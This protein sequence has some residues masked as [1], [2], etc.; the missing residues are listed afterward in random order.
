V[1]TILLIVLVA[2]PVNLSHGRTSGTGVLTQSTYTVTFSASGLPAGSTW[3]VDF[4]G[5]AVSPVPYNDKVT[6]SGIVSGTWNFNVGSVPGYNADPSAGR[7]E[8]DGA[9]V[10]KTILFTP[11]A[12]PPGNGPVAQGSIPPASY[13]LI[14][15]IVVAAV[16]V[17]TVGVFILSKRRRE[18]VSTTRKS[19][20]Y[21]KSRNGT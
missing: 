18:R 1:S 16:M 3:S 11:S 13:P 4:Q 15:G 2:P 14:V 20:N 9:N 19:S 7:I 5:A 6:L 8:V 10:S 21:Q 17:T 12:P